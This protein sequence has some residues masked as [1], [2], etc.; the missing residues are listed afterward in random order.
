MKDESHLESATPPAGPAP[1]DQPDSHAQEQ[2]AA[3]PALFRV[4]NPTANGSGCSA[5]QTSLWSYGV[6]VPPDGAVAVRVELTNSPGT[7][8]G[9]PG[10]VVRAPFPPGL[11]A[12]VAA[13]GANWACQVTGLPVGPPL[14]YFGQDGAPAALTVSV[15]LNCTR[16][17]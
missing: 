9:A 12:E 15:P 6:I 3:A 16:V 4:L 5:D 7:Q 10:A 1:D 8:V 11:P 2:L 14:T 13:S 17:Q